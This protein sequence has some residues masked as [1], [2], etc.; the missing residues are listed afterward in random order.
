M[1]YTFSK[2]RL[3]VV[4]YYSNIIRRIDIETEKRLIQD[5]VIIRDCIKNYNTNSEWY[6]NYIRS[7]FIKLIEDRRDIILDE[8]NKS[9]KDKFKIEEVIKTIHFNSKEFSL[10]YLDK[11][12][13]HSSIYK[14]KQHA[15]IGEFMISNNLN[16]Y[17][18]LINIMNITDFYD[19]YKYVKEITYNN[20]EEY[21]YKHGSL[22]DKWGDETGETSDVINIPIDSNL[23]PYLT[24]LRSLNLAYMKN[25]TLETFQLTNLTSLTIVCCCNWVEHID[26]LNNLTQ[27]THLNIHCALIE[28]IDIS[29]LVQLTNLELRCDLSIINLSMLVRLEQLDLCYNKIKT[30]NLSKLVKLKSLNL[31]GNKIQNI[32]LSNLVEL[33][34]LD[35]C[36]NKLESLNINHLIIL[37]ELNIGDNKLSSIPINNLHLLKEL[38]ASENKLD[39][40]DF[41][42]LINL[43]DV[44]ISNNNIRKIKNISKAKSLCIIVLI[45]NMITELPNDI[46][47]LHDL[48]VLDISH[49]PIVNIPIFDSLL[50]LKLKTFKH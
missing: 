12:L 26:L 6:L 11:Y 43:K 17:N 42:G 49:N 25:I 23:L 50:N 2:I 45:N 10:F 22:F 28:Y 24:S 31:R 8:I 27:L 40:I 14:I 1:E 15:T 34:S 47:L 3:E 48:K 33:K 19:I 36:S 20:V 29:N 30:I 32:D 13:S 41:D 18:Y 37:E 9:N 5:N 21:E 39:V 7:E 46:L 35:L 16:I 4:E 38:N 44:I